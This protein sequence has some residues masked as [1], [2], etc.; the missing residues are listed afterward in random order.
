LSLES[1]YLKNKDNLSIEDIGIMQQM[2]KT[3]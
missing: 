1:S 2:H 3:I